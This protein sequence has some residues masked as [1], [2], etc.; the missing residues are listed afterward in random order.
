MTFDHRSAGLKCGIEIHQRLDTH[1]LF[2]GCSSALEEEVPAME[3]KRKLRAVA[4][5]LG[6]VDRAALHEYLRDRVFLYNAYHGETC[7]V[8]LDEE[9]PSPLNEEALDIGLEI[10]LLFSA[11]TPDEIHVMRKTVVDGSNTGGFQRTCVI[12]LDGEMEGPRGRLSVPAI[13]LEEEAAG[14]GGQKDGS[15][16]Y[17][18]DRLG[19]PLVEVATGL[20]EGYSPQEVQEIAH[21]IGMIVRMTGKVLRGIGTIR[22]DVNVSVRGG[23][24]VEIKGFQEIGRLAEL[25]EKEAQRQ[26]SL[27]RMKDEFAKRS[28]K[29]ADPVDVTSFFADVMKGPIHSAVKKGGVVLCLELAAFAGMLRCELCPGRTFG[30]ELADHARAYGLGGIIHTDE[31]LEA[32]G[33]AGNF[34]RLR[35]H[36]GAG[37]DDALLI[38]AGERGVLER[39]MK[40]VKERADLAS[41]GLPEETREPNPDCT[42]NYKR[43]LPGS[44]RMYPETD[45]P[46]IPISKE[47]LERLRA[48]LP[49]KPE[50]KRARLVEAGMSEDLAD[51]MVRDANLPLF[52]SVMSKVKVDAT[53]V[54]NML[55]NSFRSLRRTGVDVD[56]LTEDQVVQFF[57]QL[58]AGTIVK[59]EIE[60]VLAEMAQGKRPLKEIVAERHRITEDDLRRIVE[61]VLAEKSQLLA[62][63]GER[64]FA[65]IMGEVMKQVRGKI[66]GALVGMVLKQLMDAKLRAKRS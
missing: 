11:W 12:G 63:R 24:R 22:Q 2:C 49:E 54:A 33:L 9:P 14:I 25:I 35:A 1:K 40:A 3:V 34:A 62:E 20:L 16:V 59:Q 64:S 58:S 43:P 65:P 60:S 27:V 57:E 44:S 51:Q 15:V 55:V 7:L 41:R 39:A 50:K 23:A 17:K 47:R 10:C 13:C 19:I 18:L 66:D 32:M 48:K 5:E 46:P 42:T 56:S 28:P 8:E 37:K 38:M 4:G 36:L 61:A 31:D 21:R 26:I 53:L 6:E 30:R 52:E 45:I 29:V